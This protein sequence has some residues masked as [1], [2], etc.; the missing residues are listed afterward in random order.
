MIFCHGNAGNLSNRV[1]NLALLSKLGLGTL[2]FE[3]ILRGD[4]PTIMGILFFSAM[5]VI[6][7]N[8]LTDLA[9]RIVDPRIR[10]SATA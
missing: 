5:V 2:A 10:M 8:L 9:Y 4:T 3:S 7:F 6:I 1:E